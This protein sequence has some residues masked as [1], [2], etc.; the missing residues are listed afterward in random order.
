MLFKGHAGYPREPRPLSSIIESS[1]CPVFDHRGKGTFR[2]YPWMHRVL[3]KG[4]LGCPW[5]T[6]PPSSIVES[7]TRPVFDDRGKETLRVYPWMCC[8]LPKGYV[9]YPGGPWLLRSIVEPST[10]TIFVSSRKELSKST[11]RCAACS[12]RIIQIVRENLGRYFQNLSATL[13]AASV[14]QSFFLHAFPHCTP[15]VCRIGTWIVLTLLE[16]NFGVQDIQLN[17]ASSF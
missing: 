11:P 15:E 5:G 3:P 17:D 2:V 8:M 7:S 4:H 9:A 1:T 14:A 10:F 16:V 13:L 6:R 12:L